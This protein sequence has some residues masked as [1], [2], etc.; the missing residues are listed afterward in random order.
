MADFHAGITSGAD[1][2]TWEDT[3]TPSRLNPHPPYFQTY[4]RVLDNEDTVRVEAWLGNPIAGAPWDYELG[5]RLFRW[6]WVEDFSGPHIPIPATPGRSAR[7]EF[8]GQAFRG[9]LGHHLLMVYRP[10][11]GSIAIPFL[12]EDAR[13]TDR[14]TNDHAV[15]TDSVSRTLI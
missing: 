9:R 3:E 4:Y 12:V 13:Q 1:L 5:G 8:T 2:Q 14:V 10:E 11:G 15:V 6:C 7:V